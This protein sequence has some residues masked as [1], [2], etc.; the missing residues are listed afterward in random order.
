MAEVRRAVKP[1]EVNYLCDKCESGMVIC[2]DQ[3]SVEEKRPHQCVI[4]GA[5]Y[6]FD[7]IYPKIVYVP[8]E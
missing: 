8:D 1:I 7:K 6:A 2:T 3:S 4:C 5:E